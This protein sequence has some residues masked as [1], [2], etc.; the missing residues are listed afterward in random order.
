VV[1]ALQKSITIKI[2]IRKPSQMT[3][4]IPERKNKANS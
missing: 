3:K 1:K 4:E 2:A